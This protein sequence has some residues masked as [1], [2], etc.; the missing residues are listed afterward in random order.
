[1]DKK[2]NIYLDKGSMADY[3]ELDR[4]LKTAA[5]KT[6]RTEDNSNPNRMGIDWAA[7]AVMLPV[8]YPYIVELRKTLASYFSYKQSQ[9][10]EF[11]II[12][13]NNGKRLEM[14]VKNVDAPSI[15][16]FMTFFN[17]VES[18]EDH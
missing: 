4:I 5:F 6:V 18:E 11:S 10:K 1:M 15:D 13:E 2:I 3:D 8:V 7:L 17:S 9:T 16:E 12:L 14:N